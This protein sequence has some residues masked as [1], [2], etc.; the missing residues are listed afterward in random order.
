MIALEPSVEELERMLATV[1]QRIISHLATLAEQPASDLQTLAPEAVADPPQ[2]GRPLEETLDTLFRRVIPPGV[3]SAGPGYL[4]FVPGG[5]VFSAALA[6]LI[7]KTVN[8]FVGLRF[9]APGLVRIEWSVIRWLCQ[10]VGFP[11]ES[12]GILTSGGSL[13][14]FIAVYTARRNR[15]PADFLNRIIYVS[16]QAHVSVRKAAQLAGFPPAN[17]RTVASDAW[18][19][20]DLSALG[21]AVLEDKARGLHPFMIVASAGTTNTGAIDDLTAIADFAAHHGLW[22][23]IDAAYGGF[24]ALTP[25]GRGLLCSLERADS[26]TLDPHKG[27]GLPY[28]TGCLLVKDLNTLYRAHS[29]GAEYLPANTELH[30]LPD[31]YDISPELSREARGLRLW[32]PLQLH[33]I[34]PFVDHLEEKL[35]LTR[36]ALA[37]L[38][39]IPGIELAAPPA[40]TV[41]AFRLVPSA[42]GDPDAA[43][44]ALLLRVN[45]RGHVFLSSTILRGRVYL[46]MCI[47]SFRTHSEH[48]AAALRDI[49]EETAQILNQT[50]R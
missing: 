24:F 46:R 6:D 47:L 39:Q 26:I 44:R 42:D 33:G 25:E 17:V 19:R 5:G 30:E 9:M 10:V 7:V 20:L 50:Q 1:G 4:G 49:R 41:L 18:F 2:W 48:I 22:L 31:F 32:L 12:G 43:S 34:Q 28:G 21:A 3:N 38:A 16:D 13:A 8:R 14:S 29:M 36:Q 23:H 37:E 11:R 27:L 45:A 15:L 40:L 35:R